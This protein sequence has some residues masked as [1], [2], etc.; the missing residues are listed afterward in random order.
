MATEFER[1]I[2]NESEETGQSPASEIYSQAKEKVGEIAHATS[3]NLGAISA[4]AIILAVAGFA[5]GWACG[6]SSARSHRY[7]Q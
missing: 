1:H 7:W 4:T 3:E 5:L 2:A 6:H